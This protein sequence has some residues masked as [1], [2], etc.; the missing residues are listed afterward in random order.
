MASN[1]WSQCWEGKQSRQIH[2]AHCLSSL[3]YRK[4]RVMDQC[5][6]LSQKQGQWCYCKDTRSC[7][8]PLTCTSC[9]PEHLHVHTYMNMY[10]LHTQPQKSEHEEA[11]HCSNIFSLLNSSLKSNQFCL[12]RLSA[13]TPLDDFSGCLKLNLRVTENF[14]YKMIEFNKIAELKSGQNIL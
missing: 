1:L 13:H 5:D 8:L 7:S 3:A 11:S 10:P 4:W 6:T 2:E 9:T 14:E 12:S